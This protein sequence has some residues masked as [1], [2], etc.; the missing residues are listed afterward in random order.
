M[1]KISQILFLSFVLIL[2][3]ILTI[4]FKFL[5][6]KWGGNLYTSIR[7]GT[8][9]AVGIAPFIVLILFFPPPGN[10]LIAIIGLFSFVDDLIGRRKIKGLPFEL[11]QLSRGMGMLLV[12]MVG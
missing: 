10:I 4:L 11:G 12:M 6:T 9:R 7:E 2:T 8:P 5:F 1:I 3:A